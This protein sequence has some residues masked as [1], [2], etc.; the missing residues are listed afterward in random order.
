M[1]PPTSRDNASVISSDAIAKIQNN[2]ETTKGIYEK[3]PNKKV[4][5]EKIGELEKGMNKNEQIAEAIKLGLQVDN[6]VIGDAHSKEAR[7]LS[8][9]KQ[10]TMQ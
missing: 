10:K 8:P 4:E 5:L 2:L 9:R 7:L 3:A 1:A 6:T